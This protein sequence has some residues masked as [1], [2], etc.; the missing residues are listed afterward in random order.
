MKTQACFPSGS[1]KLVLTE[2][3]QVNDSGNLLWCRWQ[4]ASNKKV[5]FALTRAPTS[6][7]LFS[8]KQ[9]IASRYLDN[10]HLSICW[11]FSSHSTNCHCLTLG[12]KLAFCS[13]LNPFTSWQNLCRES[14]WD[15]NYANTWNP[16]KRCAWPSSW[17]RHLPCAA[18]VELWSVR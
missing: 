18:L 13:G 12:V 8:L 11:Y 6:P 17:A 15:I 16:P 3:F 1:A 4:G 7:N 5:D 14:K 10:V 9:I 2:N